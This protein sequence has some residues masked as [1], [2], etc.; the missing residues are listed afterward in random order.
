VRNLIKRRLRAATAP[1]L[2]SITG[3]V[4][5][6]VL[7]AATTATYVQLR[8]ELTALVLRAQNERRG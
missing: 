2:S 1:L 7:P 4:V 6:R 3:D 8:D 5:V